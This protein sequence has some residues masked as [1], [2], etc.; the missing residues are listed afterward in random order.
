MLTNPMLLSVP[1]VYNYGLCR[2]PTH[3]LGFK[4][5]QYFDY[6]TCSFTRDSHNVADIVIILATPYQIVSH[7]T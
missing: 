1:L 2:V 3:A 6:T 5:F 7:N 4:Y